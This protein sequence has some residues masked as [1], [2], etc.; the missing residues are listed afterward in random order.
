MS[1]EEE[2]ISFAYVAVLVARVLLHVY[3]LFFKTCQQ[4][5]LPGEKLPRVNP[6]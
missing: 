6:P 3:R 4:H 1:S 2:S 5:L